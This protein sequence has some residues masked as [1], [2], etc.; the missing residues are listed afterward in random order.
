MLEFFL[1]VVCA[2]F[3]NKKNYTQKFFFFLLLFFVL[4][5]HFSILSSPSHSLSLSI[6]VYCVLS[7]LSFSKE[8]KKVLYMFWWIENKVKKWWKAHFMSLSLSLTHSIARDKATQHVMS[9]TCFIVLRFD[10]WA[11]TIFPFFNFSFSPIQNSSLSH[12]LYKWTCVHAHVC[13]PLDEHTKRVNEKCVFMLSVS[14]L[15]YF[16]IHLFFSR[17]KFM[18]HVDT[19]F[20]TTVI[21][22]TIH[23]SF[24]VFHNI[25]K[26]NI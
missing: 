19:T 26:K 12:S 2:V 15:F 20:R 5:F 14:L 21:T 18:F 11:S 4:F 10:V 7:R 13:T 1:C 17:S 9:W 24:I 8:I 16:L 25:L 23:A 6:C 22:C 3:D